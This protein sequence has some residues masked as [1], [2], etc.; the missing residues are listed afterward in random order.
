MAE[1][2]NRT[3]LF[4]PHCAE[5]KDCHV[6][7]RPTTVSFRGKD[8]PAEEQFVRCL[9]CNQEFDMF[10]LMDPI[11]QVHDQY[12]LEH[13]YP[14]A[15]EIRALRQRMG[16]TEDQFGGHIG[17][18]GSTVR[19]YERGAIPK[20]A[21]AAKLKKLVLVQRHADCFTEFS[22]VTLPSSNSSPATTSLALA[23]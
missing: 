17:T 19:F 5:E 20:E 10:G 9:S 4:C 21:H 3:N 13:G 18:T 1:T 11:K 12:R 16:L 7:Q 2:I 6:I 14:T 22:P 15:D 23:A 8:Y